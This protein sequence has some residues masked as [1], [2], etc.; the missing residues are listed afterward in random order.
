MSNNHASVTQHFDVAA[1]ATSAGT[2]VTGASVDTQGWEGCE[3]AVEIATANAD[4]FLKV[5]QSA[6]GSTGWSDLAGTAAVAGTNGD[7]VRVDVY[8]PEKRYLRA[9]VD[10]G[11]AN[12]AT[13]TLR[14]TLYGA[15]KAPEHSSVEVVVYAAT[16][17]EGTP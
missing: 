4:N 5:Q 6:D 8:R 2:D 11:G 14:A 9:V 17:A 1:A 7:T 12:T 10:R 13:T 15:T 3:F 16:P